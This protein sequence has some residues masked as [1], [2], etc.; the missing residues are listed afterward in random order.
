MSCIGWQRNTESGLLS[1]GR[2]RQRVEGF[3]L[4]AVIGSGRVARTE[5]PDPHSPAW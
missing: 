1:G 4:S 3:A 5:P 2:L